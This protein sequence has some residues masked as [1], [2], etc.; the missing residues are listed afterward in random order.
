MLDKVGVKISHTDDSFL[1]VRSSNF[2]AEVFFVDRKQAAKTVAD[3]AADICICSE[4]YVKQ[5]DMP[6]NH[7]ERRLGFGKLS[8]SLLVPQDV[9]YDGLKWFNGKI[10]ATPY[11][12]M[13]ASFF[14]VNNIKAV[15]RCVEEH[16]H[17]TI[18]AGLADAVLDKVYS[19]SAIINEH[20]REVEKVMQ[21][22]AVM[23][24]A[25]DMAPS[26]RL[27]VD[28]LLIRIDSVIAARGKKLISMNAPAEHVAEIH[29]LFPSVSN[30]T[31]TPTTAGSIVSITAVIDEA[32]LWDSID[33]LK[34]LGVRDIVTRTVDNLIL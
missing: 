15:V 25:S 23:L 4:L 33:K 7:I 5:Y 21:S 32:R 34:A 31:V 8:L 10:V 27:I 2:P 13:L 20:L 19:G 9:K 3:G 6:A 17:R 26:K 22:E 12:E 18:N 1:L 30:M 11:P 29:K 28:E 16:A 14:K 24:I